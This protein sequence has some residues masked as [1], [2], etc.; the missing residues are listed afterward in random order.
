MT[1]TPTTTARTLLTDAAGALLDQRR[2]LAL[3]P[4]VKAGQTV[5][6]PYDHASLLRT[7]E[8]SFGI[9]S[10]LNNAGASVA[11]RDLFG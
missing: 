5:S 7:V 9:G 11:M 6:T 3:G 8:D 4:G 10:Y 2:L 1:A